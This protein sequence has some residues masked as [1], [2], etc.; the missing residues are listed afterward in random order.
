MKKLSFT[1]M[2]SFLL[3]FMI[4]GSVNATCNSDISK[5]SAIKSFLKVNTEEVQLFSSEFVHD[6]QKLQNSITISLSSNIVCPKG[7]YCCSWNGSGCAGC[8]PTPPKKP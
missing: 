2:F 5:A 7:E 8:C 3:F 1:F 6:P 4:S